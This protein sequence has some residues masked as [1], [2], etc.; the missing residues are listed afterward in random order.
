MQRVVEE[1][2][3]DLA[4]FVEQRESLTLVLW[5][6]S[7]TDTVFALKLL[8]SLDEVSDRDVFVVFTEDC[9]DPSRYVDSLMAA[10]DMEIETGNAAIEAGTGSDRAAP[11]EALPAACFEERRGVQ[12]RVRALVEHMRRYY[13]EVAHRLVFAFLPRELSAPTAYAT[14]VRELLPRRGY[15][16][17]MAG[18][19]FIVIDSQRAPQLVPELSKVDSREVLVRPIDFSADAFS[20]A[21]VDQVR[22][23][24][25]PVE[26]RMTAL[27]QV[28]ALDHAWR[29]YPEALQKYGA[30]YAHYLSVRNAPMQAVCMLFAG[31]T[32]EQMGQAEPAKE[33]YRQAL[34]LGLQEDQRQI[35]LNAFLALG[36]LHQREMDWK[37]AADYWTGAAFTAKAMNNP[38]AL[39]DAAENA[40][41]CHLALNETPKTLEHWN[42]AHAVAKQVGYWVRDVSVLE[43]LVEVEGREKMRD[44]QAA[45]ERELV[46]ARH[47]L[48]SQEHENEQA[49]AAS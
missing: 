36:T 22:D 18:V 24:S 46:L 28:A 32:L 14:F 27:V 16:P 13:P 41:L 33:K 5:A 31:H 38:F 8:E 2:R 29:R 15:E 35:M 10:C 4:A 44:E 7:P 12:G 39:A 26:E 34:E 19:R 3:E 40:G 49:R 17:W 6:K 1:L 25:T 30:A 21:L 42:A 37:G 9:Y 11:W 47:E 20:Q 23:P 43:H 45:H 48:S